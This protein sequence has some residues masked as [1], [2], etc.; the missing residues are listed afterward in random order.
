MV[1]AR[2]VAELFDG[3]LDHMVCPDVQRQALKDAI[4]RL[5]GCG[6]DGIVAALQELWAA[7]GSVSRSVADLRVQTMKATVSVVSAWLDDMNAVDKG[8]F[9]GMCL[10]QLAHISPEQKLTCQLLASGVCSFED[11][12]GAASLLADVSNDN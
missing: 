7:L 12:L 1:A 3:E 8:M 4:G 9:A 2:W 5:A 10:G 6:R 11:A